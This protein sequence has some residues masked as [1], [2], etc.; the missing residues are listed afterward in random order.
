MV[1]G[2]NNWSDLTAPGVALTVAGRPSGAGLIGE[3][4]PRMTT[5]SHQLRCQHGHNRTMDAATWR[6]LMNG[7][8]VSQ[9]K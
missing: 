8:S 5:G 2:I 9:V 1:A 4:A 7:K 6:I 3:Q